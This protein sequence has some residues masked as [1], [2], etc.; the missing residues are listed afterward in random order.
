MT[1]RPFK[2]AG[3]KL[4]LATLLAS[5]FALHP[6]VLLAAQ[7]N[8]TDTSEQVSEQEDAEVITIVAHRQPRNISQVAGTVTIMDQDYIERNIALNI[9]DLVRYEPGIEVDDSS[10]RF[11]YGGF[12]IRGIGGNRTVTV[13]RKS[14]V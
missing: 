6:T 4:Y 14:V 3:S 13:D 10:T 2:R 7:S 5:T 11:G 12:R 8:S 1:K 9:D